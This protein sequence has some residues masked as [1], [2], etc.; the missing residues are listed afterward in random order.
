VW[1][2]PISR[3]LLFLAL[4]LLV[5]LLVFLAFSIRAETDRIRVRTESAAMNLAQ[6]SAHSIE[7]QLGDT[8]QFL[9]TLAGR[10]SVRAVERSRCDPVFSDFQKSHPG[11]TAL[12]TTTLDG[13]LVCSSLRSGEE[14]PSLTV[15]LGAGSAGGAPQ[16]ALGRT[17][18][19]FITGRWVLP[20][21]QAVLDDS[22]NARGNIAAWLDLVRLSPLNESTLS[23]LPK[24]TVST[25]L[26]TTAWFWQDPGM[27]KNGWASTALASRRRHRH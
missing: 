6:I 19:G 1:S 24:D 13:K 11:F 22:G 18:K 2:W 8:Q 26:T 14:K 3:V 10:A 7:R 21:S 27:R 12:T 16:F 23:R 4:V 15:A 20:I 17:Q 25:L 9:A 5:P